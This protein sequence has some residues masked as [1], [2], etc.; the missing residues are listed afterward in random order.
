MLLHPARLTHA[1]EVPPCI[2][3]HHKDEYGSAHRL[4]AP[5]KCRAAQSSLK[6]CL[7]LAGWAV[8]PPDRPH[9][10]RSGQTGQ[11][12]T[13]ALRARSSDACQPATK[14]GNADMADKVTGSARQHMFRWASVGCIRVSMLQHCGLITAVS[15]GIWH[16]CG[17]PRL[18]RSNLPTH[19]CDGQTM[20]PD[21][22]FVP[23]LHLVVAHAWTGSFK[24]NPD[25]KCRHDVNMACRHTG[26]TGSAARLLPAA[27]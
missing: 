14:P 12:P 22:T 11:S 21:R 7:G 4:P 3:V 25:V 15:P 6:P 19:R 10:P 13:P 1:G 16:L 20:P 24:W 18:A 17:S 9:P 5:S 8:R 26:R 27:S 2:T 23:A